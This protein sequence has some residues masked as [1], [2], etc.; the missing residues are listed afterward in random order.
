MKMI[1]LVLRALAPPVRARN[2]RVLGAL[3][4][5]FVA[6]VAV[7][8]SVFHAIMDREGQAHS[9]ATAVYWTLVTMTT[10]G[11]GDITFTSDLGRLFSI[12]VLLSGFAFLLVLLPFT[13][14][15]FVVTPWMAM[16][17]AARA[18]RVLAE[19]MRAHLVL[20]ALGPI[21]DALIRRAD[22]AGVRYVIVTADLEHALRLHD[23]GYSVM[24]GEL[25][26]PATY[27][28]ARV[29]SSALVATTSS[30]IANTN[31]TFTV[32]EVSSDVLVVATVSSPAALDNLELAGADVV[33]RLAE[34]LGRAMADRAV[35][36]AG[37]S[38]VIGGFGEL[39]I[40]E[41]LASGT[42]L[43]GRSLGEVRLR[44]RFGIGVLGVWRRGHFEIAT[45]DTVLDAST[46]VLLAGTPE[47]LARYDETFAAGPTEIASVVII[48]GGRVG[49][50]AG[51][52]LAEAGVPYRIIER[53]PARIGD[54][55]VYIEGDAD[56][57][58]VLEAAGIRTCSAVVITTHDDDMNVYLT[59][60]C[61]RLHEDVRIAGRANVDR[62]V[63][64]MYRA[65]ADAVL[66]YASIGATAIWNRFRSNDILL[67][68]EGLS[69]FRRP[70]PGPL[71]GRPLR[72][73]H[74]RRLTGCNVVA[75]EHRGELTPNPDPAASLPAGG[76]L[77]LI[78]DA[79]AEAR[80]AER[81]GD[82]P[83]SRRPRWSRRTP[84][85]ADV[86]RR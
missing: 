34:M 56:D 22:H 82:A 2:T 69:L 80:Y 83:T 26:D 28:A 58:A 44:A 70:V 54:P 45:A 4:V 27:R 60:Y 20:T 73:T 43:V 85:A 39:Q 52:A 30:D 8:S 31:I 36:P 38:H 68:A 5:L 11:F 33:L 48:G 74:I 53:D 9:W 32:R 15:Q 12:L 79:D 3:L 40:A 41:A 23:R 10:A 59:L 65:G 47:Q 18:P 1:A 29:E 71:A 61:R 50:A 24:V 37:R 57:I 17:E 86:G 67:V 78:G 49:R 76:D 55:D 6:L 84:D 51:H 16:R 14:I 7:Y 62:N 64:T 72:D 13:F 35:A 81:F 21:E 42:E 75:I 19:D 25:D 66:S 77:L 63:S 46:V